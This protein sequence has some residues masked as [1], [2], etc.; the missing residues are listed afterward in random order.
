[1]ADKPVRK[2]GRGRWNEQQKEEA[3]AR[4][5]RLHQAWRFLESE[6]PSDIGITLADIEKAAKAGNFPKDSKIAVVFDFHS[7]VTKIRSERE[8]EG[9]KEHVQLVISIPIS[10]MGLDDG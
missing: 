7:E 2:R 10:V 6:K 4:N 5:R 9:E 8:F 1:M 3:S